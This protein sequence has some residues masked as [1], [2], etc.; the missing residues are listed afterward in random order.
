LLKDH[1][2]WHPQQRI[3]F[4]IEVIENRM[5]F[6]IRGCTDVGAWITLCQNIVISMIPWRQWVE[7]C[8]FSKSDLG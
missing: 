3:Y 6:E 2:N 8:S 1:W 7:S 4:W 5:Q